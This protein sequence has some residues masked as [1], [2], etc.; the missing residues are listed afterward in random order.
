MDWGFILFNAAVAMAFC[1]SIAD[2]TY[3][4]LYERVHKP[5]RT[6][7]LV[8]FVLTEGYVALDGKPIFFLYVSLNIFGLYMLWL[9]KKIHKPKKEVVEI[10][11]E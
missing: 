3:A 7:L 6:L 5:T 9:H 11:H 4:G 2:H 10:H 8:L 1:T